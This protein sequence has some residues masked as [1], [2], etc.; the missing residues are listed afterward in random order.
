MGF[1]KT[2]EKSWRQ[3]NKSEPNNNIKKQQ[4]QTTEIDSWL[5]I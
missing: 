3:T 1:L 2:K 5:Q 4:Q